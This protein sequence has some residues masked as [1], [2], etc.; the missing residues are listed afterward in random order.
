MTEIDALVKNKDKKADQKEVMSNM[1]FEQLFKVMDTDGSGYIEPDEIESLLQAYEMWTYEYTYKQTMEELYA[2][3]DNEQGSIVV[4]T[5]AGRFQKTIRIISSPQYELVM[6]LITILNLFSV[7]LPH[8]QGKDFTQ[9]WIMA[10]IIINVVLFIE[11]V[12]D[13]VI[14]GLGSAYRNH[15]RIWPETL[16]QILNVLAIV[17]FVNHLNDVTEYNNLVKLFELIVFIRLLKLLT[18]LYEVQVMRI[19]FETLRN[20]I[21]PLKD[22]LAVMITIMY[23]FTELGM[24]IFGGQVKTTS[25]NIVHDSSIPDNY[26]LMNFNDLISGMVT[27]FVLIVVNNWYVIV[28]MFVDIK[29]G[30]IIYRTY[31][32]IFYYFG[33][34]IGLNIIIA[35]A[36]DMYSAVNRL[37]E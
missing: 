19:I 14:S 15:F 8:S 26:Y 18:L 33:V 11:M 6:N 36:I 25:P 12:G 13:L 22:L 4:N 1:Q 9:R 10:Q 28:A 23:V 32:M 21:G 30:N 27:L 17:R 34:V 20:L 5:A 35:F 16:C 3:V 37:D 31:F 7:I 24:A 29:G 2:D